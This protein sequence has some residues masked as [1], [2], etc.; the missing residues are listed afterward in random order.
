MI[1]M[2]SSSIDPKIRTLKWHWNA[3]SGHTLSNKQLQNRQSNVSWKIYRIYTHIHIHPARPTSFIE[4]WR[5]HIYIYNQ[6][7]LKTCRTNAQKQCQNRIPLFSNF[8]ESTQLF[9]EPRVH[10]VVHLSEVRE[11]PQALKSRGRRAWKNAVKIPLAWKKNSFCWKNG[12]KI[13]GAW[14]FCI[15][16]TFFGGETTR[17]LVTLVIKGFSQLTNPTKDGPKLGG[18]KNILSVLVLIKGINQTTPSYSLFLI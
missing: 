2:W 5:K 13:L 15:S 16:V 3:K 1:I 10:A 14:Q 7:S 8:V 18:A 17:L 4:K 11:I 6:A 12:G 9:G